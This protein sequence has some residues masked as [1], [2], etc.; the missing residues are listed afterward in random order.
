MA[1]KTGKVYV[2]WVR[3]GIGFPRRQKDMV[4]SLGLR[5]L[6]QVVERPDTV[7]IRGL[8]ASVPHLVA[9]V[10]PPTSPAWASLPEYRIVEA[11]PKSVATAKKARKEAPP[12]ATAVA[13]GVAPAPAAP[14]KEAAP[15]EGVAVSA[16][17]KTRAKKARATEA[18]KKEAPADSEKAK[19]RRKAPE[20]KPK[21]AEKSKS[22][23]GKK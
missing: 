21:A 17:K 6:N 8:V 9:I 13:E 3:S 10:D 11:K 22:K 15:A 12:K 2:K 16:P 14:Q 23:K 4:R 1:E 18:A 20:S 5:R 7:H 19:R